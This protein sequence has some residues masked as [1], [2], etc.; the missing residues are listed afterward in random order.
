[1]GREIAFVAMAAGIGKRYGGRKQL[2]TFGSDKFTIAEY[3][4]Q[5]AIEAGF[6]K[7]YFVVDGGIAEIFHRRLSD[8]LPS[9]CSLELI[10]QRSEEQLTKFYR[11]EKPWGT[12]HAVMC[13][14]NAIG[15][16]FCTTNAD[17]LYG[18]DAIFKI[19]EFL[20]SADG[21]SSVFANVAYGLSETLSSGGT[22]SRG[23]ITADGGFLKSI[24]ETHGICSGSI[25]KNIPADA[26]VSMNLWGFTPEVFAML[27][28][29][30]KDFL[31][32]VSALDVDEF[33]LPNFINS[34]LKNGKCSVR[35]L[36]TS[37]KW[38]GVT[39]KS[40]DG[41]VEDALR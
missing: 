41:A 9:N 4:V 16:N 27:R 10:H 13:C 24:G 19:A 29:C 35:I 40:D 33:G 22:V 36:N 3:N 18:R 26:I 28:S 11:R 21:G 15:C 20:R 25:G 2:Q 8:L 1:M 34:A 12:A 38:V 6:E 32:N 23:I 39:H 14:E 5:H 37:S 17:D 7:F 31:K 30:W